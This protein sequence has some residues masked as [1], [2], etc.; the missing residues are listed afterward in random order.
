[1]VLL[2]SFAIEVVMIMQSVFLIITNR[3]N[4]WGNTS[5]YL[6]LV[7]AIVFAYA[8]C[9]RY[10]AGK[11]STN[12]FRRITSVF[13]LLVML[14]ATTVSLNDQ[15][16]YSGITVYVSMLFLCASV[17]ICAPVI[18]FGIQTAVLAVFYFA[19]PYYQQ[20]FFILRGH[21]INGTIAFVLAVIGSRL[22]YQMTVNNIINK[23][24]AARRSNLIMEG[25]RYASKIQK[26][27]LPHNSEFES[28]F[29]DYSV[30]WEPRDIVGGDIYWIKQFDKGTVLCVCDCTGHGTPGAF[31]T[32]LVTSALESIIWPS[33]CGDT[34]GIVW[35]LDQRLSAVLHTGLGA[36]GDKR[37]IAN[38]DDGCD[39]AVLF[40]AKD[41]TVTFSSGKIPIFVCDGHKV[42]PYKG[43]KIFIGE[44]RLKNK[45]EVAISSIPA[46]PDNKFYIASDGLF[47]Q[48]GSTG[49]QFGY[50][51][52]MQIILENHYEKQAVITGRIWSAFEE[53]RG[54]QARRD[55]FE[56]VAFRP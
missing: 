37:K 32:M 55:D 20:N 13:L 15:R 27:L 44:G 22:A 4:G 18:F 1:V 16:N 53:F 19:L 12:V 6:F 46:N 47:E 17:A 10:R 43:Q 41:G 8:L 24:A 14:W 5:M 23:E 34:A 29:L 49:K 26:N 11:V 25:I 56:L 9:V 39:L 45:D 28:A 51:T 40:I 52:F 35:Q 31:L 42:T 54:E 50:K 38:I 33:N 3:I 36:G 21:Y 30:I 7:L 48:I 2:I